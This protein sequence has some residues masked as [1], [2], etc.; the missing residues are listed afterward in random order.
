MF[1]CYCNATTLCRA[2][3][4]V[5][6]AK[7]GMNSSGSSNNIDGYAEKKF[8]TLKDYAQNHPEIKWGFVRAVG[9]QIRFS[10]T[11]WT[12]DMTNNNIWKPIEN[13]I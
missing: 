6:E 9:S 13:F 4:W 8:N 11:N 2:Y 12:E 1:R 10:N 5:I 7:G 3:I